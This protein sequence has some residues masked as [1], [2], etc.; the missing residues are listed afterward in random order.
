MTCM[1][2]PS[3]SYGDAC[4]DNPSCG[5]INGQHILGECRNSMCGTL[6]AAGEFDTCMYGY[7]CAEGLE[8]DNG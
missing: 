5:N 4:T 7:E 1:D 2:I 6:P 8:C 3:A